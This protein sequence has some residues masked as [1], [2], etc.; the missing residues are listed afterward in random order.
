MLLAS[1]FS[2][3]GMDEHPGNYFFDTPHFIYLL[4]NII[5][6]VVLWKILKRRSKR[7]QDIMITIFLILIIVLKYAGDILFIY[8]YYNV[9]PLLSSYPHPFWDVDTFFSFQMCG[10]T[11]ILLPITIWFKIKG[12][13]EFVFLSSILGGIAVILYPVTVLYGHPY[14]LTLPIIRSTF[15]HFFL[16][17]IPIFLINRG[18]FKPNPKHWWHIA[19]GIFFLSMWALFGN[20]VIDVGNNNLYLM[21]NPFFGGPI[22]LLNQVPDG[23]HII[24]MFILVTIGYAIIY[25]ITSLIVPGGFKKFISKFKKA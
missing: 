23:W 8:E 4:F 24:L 1:F 15:V 21:E 22:P 3:A 18:D 6:F 5:L 20:L 11:N 12:L 16:L 19:I 10:V 7:T 14:A 17:F 9:T 13:R 25:F 2:T